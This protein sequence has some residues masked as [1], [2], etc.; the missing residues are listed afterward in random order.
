[1]G[2]I[3]SAEAKTS[4]PGRRDPVRT[5]ARQ[6]SHQVIEEVRDLQPAVDFSLRRFRSEAEIQAINCALGHTGWNRRR[7]AKLLG[8]S[9]RGLLYKIRRHDIAQRRVLLSKVRP[10]P[11]IGLLNVLAMPSGKKLGKDEK[12]CF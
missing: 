5:E 3:M 2:L 10:E 12:K 4:D 1:M 7:A 6:S 9:Y 11:V 8:I